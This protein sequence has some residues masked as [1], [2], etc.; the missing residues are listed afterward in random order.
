MAKTGTEGVGS[1]GI[2]MVENVEDVDDGRRRG[3]GGRRWRWSGNWSEGE[4]DCGW[5]LGEI[6]RDERGITWAIE[7]EGEEEGWMWMG[8]WMWMW[9][10]SVRKDGW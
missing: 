10:E 5:V 7:V 1:A 9:L 8:S 4:G 2:A 3:V 6:K